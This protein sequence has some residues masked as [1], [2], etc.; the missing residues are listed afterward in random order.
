M[1]AELRVGIYI[2][3][4][5]FVFAMVCMI[6]TLT[7]GRMDNGQTAGVPECDYLAQQ[8]NTC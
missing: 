8:T 6:L 7:A 2:A 4:L 3:A 5:V 1:S